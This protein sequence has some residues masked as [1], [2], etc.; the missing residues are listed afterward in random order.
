MTDDCKSIQF[1]SFIE[2]IFPWNVPLVSLIFLKRSLVSHSIV[3]LYV[4][5]LTAEKFFLISPCYSLELFIQMGISFLFF[6]LLFDS[7]L[8]IA[9]CKASLDIHFAFL[10]FFFLGWSWSPSPVQ[11]H[12][13]PFIVYPAVYQIYHMSRFCTFSM[14]TMDVNMYF[15]S[16]FKWFERK[17][18]VLLWVGFGYADFFIGGLPWL[19]SVL[20]PRGFAASNLL[21]FLYASRL[22]I[23][24]LMRLWEIVFRGNSPNQVSSIGKMGASLFW[25]AFL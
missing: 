16:V 22:C 1:L 14:H 21:M 7:F 3:F 23:R 9:I 24:T 5:A 4:F 25:F 13:P 11:C 20:F 8:Y 2:P 10:L 12:E 15:F 18:L 6:P 19:T 17:I